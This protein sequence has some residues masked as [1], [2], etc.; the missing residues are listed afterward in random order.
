MGKAQVNGIVATGPGKRIILLLDGTWND[1][2]FGDADT[3]IVRLREAIAQYIGMPRAVAAPTG[4]S[5]AATFQD[6][7]NIVFY[8]R[9]VGTGPLLDR[10]TGG[11]FGI[12][13]A[14]NV[15]RAYRFLS[16]HY[17]VGD[18]IFIF[19]FSRGAYTA[20]S[21][22]GYIEAIGLLKPEHCTEFAE[23]QAW[24]YYRVP[25]NDRMP[26]IWVSLKDKMH[27]R[28]KVRVACLGLF[29]SVG[30]LGIPLSRFKVANRE[31]YEFH[32]V[33][34]SN[35]TNVNLHALAIDEHREPFEASVW[36]RSKFV[37]NTAKTE[38]VWF[39]GA[40]A[41]IGGGY[42][43]AK[44][45]REFPSTLDDITLDWMIKRVKEHFPQFPIDL[46]NVP[47]GDV[48][49]LR[50][51]AT[52][53]VQ[54]EARR[55]G[56]RFLPTAYRTLASSPAKY[57]SL[58]IVWTSVGSVSVGYDR[59]AASYCESVHISAVERLGRL[60]RLE[61]GKR[62]YAPPNLVHI[63]KKLHSDLMNPQQN[64][65]KI[66]DWDGKPVSPGS[67]EAKRLARILIK[68]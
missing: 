55:G 68:F 26:G 41:D 60:G 13:L 9:G 54:H 65:I 56:Y 20:R 30:A 33:D 6:R 12:G 40:H 57:R 61:K 51:R 53:A 58:N 17:D 14:T 43:L 3:N 25:P 52:R 15:R 5:Q 29:E 27:P 45:R 37:N 23:Q 28:D 2:D 67:N 11:A 34:L 19:G 10:W 39:S 18:E 4:G 46:I 31:H 38:Q 48:K 24:D 42:I 62:R 7:Q 22:V 35:I 50:K 63:A 64:G 44:D 1:A 59:H 16:F 21:L 8:E 32:S 36:R 47:E 66:I 49:K